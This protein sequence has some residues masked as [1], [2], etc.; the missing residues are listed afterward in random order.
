MSL[1]G[2]LKRRNVFR[3]GIAYVVVAWLVLQVVDVILNNIDAPA[4]VFFVTLMLLGAGFIIV[5][6]F[7]WVFEMTSEGVKRESEVDR[8]QSIV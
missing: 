8:S 7:S 5:L 1:F 2:E 4:W 3:A 6:V